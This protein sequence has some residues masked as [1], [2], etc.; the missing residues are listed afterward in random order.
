MTPGADSGDQSVGLMIE[1][2][3]TGLHEKD[4]GKA[5][6]GLNSLST[7]NNCPDEEIL[8]SVID[9]GAAR[10]VC[11]IKHGEQFGLHSTAQSRS[12][13]GFRTATNKRV[14]NLGS[15]QVVGI[16]DANQK[17]GMMYAVAN[18]NVALDSVSQICDSAEG[19]WFGKTGGYIL[20]ADGKKV[21][22]RRD[23]DTYIRE[24]R[25]PKAVQSTPFHRQRISA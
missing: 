24:V 13:A 20:E 15:R 23:G 5:D 7:A 12:G 6:P 22:F 19:V 8:R 9:S 25:V 14:P 16:N 1:L 2:A 21:P 17:I 10:S 3:N 11:P 4:V 18:V